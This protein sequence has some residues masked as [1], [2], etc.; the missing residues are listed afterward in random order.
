M[1]QQFYEKALPSQ[2]VYCVT[3]I[4]DGKATNRFA[5]TLSDMLGIIEELKQSESNVFVA[6]N[7]YNNF[8]RK[9]DNAA[10]CKTLFIDLD[11]G[12]D[13]KKYSTKEAA[14]EALNDFLKIAKLPP[15]V[16]VDSG[17]GVHAYW[18]FDRDIPSAEW[19][20][21]SLL[22]KKY[23]LDYMKIDP[24]V[25]G[26]TARVMRCPDTLNYK[27]S[28]PSPTALLGEAINVYSWDKFKAFL[29]PIEPTTEDILSQIAKGMD[30]DTAVI[31]KLANY[32]NYEYT[33]KPIAIKSLTTDGG[34]AQIKNVL[35]NAK[36]LPEPLWRAGL[37]VAIR[38]VDGKE[39]IHTMSKGHPGYDPRQT[40]LKAEATL[41]ATAAYGCA[42]FDQLNPG[43]CEGCPFR[44]KIY[45][46]IEL[47]REIK[48]APTLEEADK[49]DAVRDDEDPQ[50]VPL[51]PTAIMPYVRGRNGGVFIVEKGKVNEE[52]EREPDTLHRLTMHDFF[53][54]KRMDGPPDGESLLL[55]YILPKDPM[56]EFIFP[57]KY[58]YAFD[59][60][61]ELLSH[62]GVN[63]DPAMAKHMSGYLIKW[64]EYMQ[65]QKAAEIVRQ[66][67]G[68]TEENKG[69]VAGKAEILVNGEIRSS[70][71]SPLAKNVYKQVKPE[72]TYEAWKKS[73]NAFN[74]EGL[75]LHA[76]G[77]LAG[78]GSP[79]MALT[80]T[81]GCTI[82][83]M[84]PESGVGK[85]GSMY[86]GASVFGNP[87]YLTV[88]EGNATDNALLNRYLSLKNIMFG[89]DEASNIDSAV[90]SK[91]IHRISQG[92]A[93]LR[94]QSSVNA[95]RDIEF[96][97]S[98]IA[99][100]TTN[101]SLADKLSLLKNSPDGE[102]ARIIEFKLV[103]PKWFEE[104]PSIS[105]KIVDPF[106]HNYGHAG[107]DF[108]QAVF[109]LG[110]P[111]VRE[112]IGDWSEKFRK[113]YGTDTAY[114]FYENA[115]A[116]SFAGGEIAVAAGIVDLDLDRI[117]RVV[118]EEMNKSRREI[119]SL[120]STDY[121]ELIATFF[122]HNHKNYL[123]FNEE[124]VV[125]EPHGNM[126]V[127]RIESDKNLH[128]IAKSEIRKFLAQPGLQVSARAAEEEWRK[129]G[130]LVDTK[131]QRLTTGWKQGTHMSA[132][133]CYVFKS[134]LPEN[135]F[136]KGT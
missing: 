45:G 5:E 118:M 19:R 71:T 85:T 68:W 40:E 110:I 49:E 77:L 124:K 30:D 79:L 90:L 78:F 105:K 41:K 115:I 113:A 35:V 25:M 123:I 38:C 73:A 116:C 26:D 11:V 54:V 28:P 51:F 65:L 103:K 15:P 13:D 22:F 66:Q 75:E 48:A 2:G 31:A 74:H 18:V 130:V 4:K 84:S 104:D 7:T 32:D 55:R 1:T 122:N 129:A 81:P 93:K 12:D 92:R 82:S 121:K 57:I 119:F 50:K 109:R 112:V 3:G 72:G 107:P 46:P 135:F 63:F 95:E 102:M 70:A 29:G 89:L 101:Q 99:V 42:A 69:F 106:N 27:R 126:I 94:M 37:S 39:A 111:R 80:N 6:L 131:K 83:Y 108:I 44:G 60:M 117:F 91:L 8:S 88:A 34:C 53:P 10:Y 14:L 98:L 133:S 61:K 136:D 125:A 43:V 23:C 33:F 36:T 52:G 56:K 58:A 20:E 132:V 114:R 67:M 120:N 59:K 64:D 96:A 127:G 86:A 62:H 134:E 17:G 87:F 128:Y 24:A 9:A 97:A 47:G 100:M 16:R 76:V 21:Y